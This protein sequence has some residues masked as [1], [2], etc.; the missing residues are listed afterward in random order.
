MQR[1]P[2]PLHPAYPFSAPCTYRPAP[3]SLLNPGTAAGLTVPTV[4][5][6][7]MT[8]DIPISQTHEEPNQA[9]RVTTTVDEPKPGAFEALKNAFLPGIGVME[10]VKPPGAGVPATTG[11]LASS[12]LSLMG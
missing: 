5:R 10:N 9:D 7:L 2:N 4:F 12:P 8:D 3:A 1:S 6:T 11:S